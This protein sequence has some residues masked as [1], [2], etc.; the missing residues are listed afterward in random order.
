MKAREPLQPIQE[1]AAARLSEAFKKW[2]VQ[3]KRRGLPSSQAE[4]AAQ[5]GWGQSAMS[6]YLRGEIPLN[7]RALQKFCS[8]LKV[9]PASI[10]W[11]LAKEMKDIAR[12]VERDAVANAEADPVV[13]NTGAD[14][15]V[16]VAFM[17]YY[18]PTLQGEEAGRRFRQTPEGFVAKEMEFFERHGVSAETVIAVLAVGNSNADYIVDG[19]ICFFDRLR[20]EPKSGKIFLVEHPDGLL[21]KV[22]RRRLDGSWVLESKNPDKA[23][24]PDEVVPEAQMALLEIWGEFF[25]RQGL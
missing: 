16:E 18:A 12:V 25:Y 15:P 22:L 10:S 24:Y 21:I 14:A 1:L 11:P 8:L 20:T 19:D 2:Q 23:N 7:V 9:D 3:Q 6:Q 13:E 4:A 17:P 5:L